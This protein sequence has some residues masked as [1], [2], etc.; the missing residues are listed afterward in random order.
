[1]ILGIPRKDKFF[2]STSQFASFSCGVNDLSMSLQFC[3]WLHIPFD[4]LLAKTS[5]ILQ[6]NNLVSPNRPVPPSHRLDTCCVES[7]PFLSCKYLLR[8]PI[9]GGM[10]EMFGLNF[11]T[12][13][14]NLTKAG[15]PSNWSFPLCG[16][17]YQVPPSLP[18]QTIWG[19]VMYGN[20]TLNFWDAF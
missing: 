6:G 16:T 12:I 4:E 3:L 10:F 7:V 18:L 17:P 9:I 13:V 15:S 11:W 14:T 20:V 8:N 19:L 2:L 5:S 1:M